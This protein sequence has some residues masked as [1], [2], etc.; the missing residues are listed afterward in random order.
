[1]IRNVCHT[2]TWVKP[3]SESE[4]AAEQGEAKNTPSNTDYAAA[5]QAIEFGYKY[6][7]QKY[8]RR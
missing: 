6:G 1:M 5:I 7:F 2:F 8:W 4:H 3:C